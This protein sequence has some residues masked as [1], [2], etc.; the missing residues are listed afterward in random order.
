MIEY[1][2]RVNRFGGASPPYNKGVLNMYTIQYKI[3]LNG[4]IRRVRRR[5]GNSEEWRVKSEEYNWP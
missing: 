1:F 4:E 3:K 2:Q 5:R